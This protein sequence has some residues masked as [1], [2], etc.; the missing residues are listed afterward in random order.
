VLF[1]PVSPA[2]WGPPRQPRHQSLW[3]PPHRTAP[4]PA[5]SSPG[6]PGPHR[7]QRVGVHPALLA[8]TADDVLS[9][10]RTALSA[11]V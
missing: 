11:R 2:E 9:A 5:R 7:E 8:L 3:R 4:P 1:G 6:A 10:V